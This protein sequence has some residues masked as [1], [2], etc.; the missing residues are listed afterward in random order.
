MKRH[1]TPAVAMSLCL[2]FSLSAT[3]ATAATKAQQPKSCAVDKGQDV[4]A[5]RKSGD[6]SDDAERVG[7]VTKRQLDATVSACSK[8]LFGDRSVC[9]RAGAL[10][11]I[12]TAYLGAGDPDKAIEYHSKAFAVMPGYHLAVEERAKAYLKLRKFDE[13]VA[14]FKQAAGLDESEG[15]GANDYM[16]LGF[17]YNMR[18]EYDVAIDYMNKAIERMPDGEIYRDNKS[19][20]YRR[21]GQ[22]WSNKG[23]TA[24]AEADFAKAKELAAKPQSTVAPPR[25]E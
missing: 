4:D 11:Y 9:N 3:G 19:E 18:G 25:F 24:R 2:G 12:G 23:D 10:R 5:C 7:E 17:L 20:F 16:A 8:L 22:Y 21:R 15:H 6:A 14:D 13:A 1:T